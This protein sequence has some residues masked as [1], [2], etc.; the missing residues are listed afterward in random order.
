MHQALNQY[1]IFYIVAGCGNFSAAAKQLYISQPAVSKAVAKLEEEL[2][3]T[4]FYRTTKGVQ[5]TDA[6]ETLYQQL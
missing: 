5:L 3:T 6:G 2:D 4:L 1:H